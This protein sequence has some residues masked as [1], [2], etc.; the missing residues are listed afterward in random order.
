[1]A[2]KIAIDFDYTSSLKRWPST[3]AAVLPVCF[4]GFDAICEIAPAFAFAADIVG[5]SAAVSLAGATTAIAFAALG[6]PPSA[7]AISVGVCRTCVFDAR[8]TSRFPPNG[9]SSFARRACL[10][11]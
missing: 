2:N 3:S 4:S 1:M 11:Y 6:F 7:L 9:C 10:T 5:G 8:A